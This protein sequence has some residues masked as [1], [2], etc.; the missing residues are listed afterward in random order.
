LSAEAPLR[1]PINEGTLQMIVIGADTYKRT[2]ALAAVY[3][4]TGGPRG[5]R[6]IKAEQD[7][8]LAALRWA[9]ELAPAD[10]PVARRYGSPGRSCP[11]P[12]PSYG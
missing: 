2:H 1:Q 5:A 9:R 8:H 7:G 12:A 11:S 6:Q 10:T 4:G 3:A